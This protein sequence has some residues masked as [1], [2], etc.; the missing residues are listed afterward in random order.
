MLEIRPVTSDSLQDLEALFCSE[1]STAGC[2]CMWFI[3]P[4]KDYHA[5]GSA[6]NRDRFEKL[7]ESSAEPIGLVAKEDG[8]AI[9]WSKSSVR[10]CDKD[11]DV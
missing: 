5:A 2:W 6:G 8:E 9:G 7:L 11:T 3:I 10:P 1:S 4:V